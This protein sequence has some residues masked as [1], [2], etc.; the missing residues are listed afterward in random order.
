M[1]QTVSCVQSDMK[2]YPACLLLH[3]AVVL[4]HVGLASLVFW[5]VVFRGEVLYYGDI[6]LYFQ[7]MLR[8]AQEWLAR[9]VLPLWNPHTLFGQ[10]FI[11]NP[12]E[13]VFYPSS[14]LVVWLGAERAISWGAVVHLA[15]AGLGV[16]AFALRR[17][18]PLASAVAAGTLWSLSGA[19]VLRSQ[20]VTILQTLAWYGW[21]LWALEGLIQ[22]ACPSRGVALSVVLTLVSLAGSPQMF[23]TLCLLLLAWFVYRWRQVEDRRATLAWAGA[24]VLTALLVGCAHWLPLLEL[25]RHTERDSLPLREVSFYSLYPDNLLLF[26]APNL[27][28]FPWNGNYILNKFYW[29]MAFF[30]GTIPVVIVLAVWRRAVD[31]ERFWKWVIVVSLWLALGP[32]GGLYLIAYY[33]VP[34]MPSF[35]APLRWTAVADLAVCLWAAR[36]LFSSLRLHPRWWRLPAGLLLLALLGLALT[37]FLAQLL[38]PSLAKAKGVSVEQAVLVVRSMGAVIQNG[39]WQAVATCALAVG[40]LSLQNR[41]RWWIAAGVTLAQL[42]WIAIPAN[43]TCPPR[44][45]QKP[46]EPIQTLRQHGQ[47]LF[48]PNTAPIWMRY[49]NPRDFG[50][51]ATSTLLSWR[52]TLASNIGMAHG[53]SEASG[54]EPA[55][56][57]SSLKHYTRLCERWRVDR[58]LLQQNGVGAVAYGE[59]A[60]EWRVEL[61]PLQGSRAWMMHEEFHPLQWSEWSPQG[62]QLYVKQTGTAILTDSA[63]PGWRVWIGGRPQPWHVHGGAFRAVEV[64]E[65]NVLVE[66]RYQPDTFRV[67]LFLTSIGLALLTGAG[68]FC[69]FG[70]NVHSPARCGRGCVNQRSLIA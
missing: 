29:E 35:R 8:F 47:R 52:E 22:R 33:V 66:W 19:L 18:Y 17:G 46:P 39:L 28:G 67:G 43:P 12:Q 21:S 41:W 16:Y 4:W 23:H 11:G 27:Y 32:K 24:A 55:A 54:Y 26:L 61:L 20:H 14:L 60:E 9:G 45:F 25:L 5:R 62:V 2:R 65:P 51:P 63:Y 56:L 34:G 10:P 31:E 58:Q 3:S 69:L 7:P 30:V 57:T 36:Y 70:R 49:V 6:M 59:T 15:W 40:L 37:P 42:C 44:V 48:V 38:A 53:V 50:S 1:H 64:S 68:V 13:F